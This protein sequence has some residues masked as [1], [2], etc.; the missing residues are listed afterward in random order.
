[1]KISFERLQYES[2]STGFRS[3]ILEKV[4]YLMDLLR[5]FS[6]DSYLKSRIALKGGTALNLFYF[7]YPRLS[8]D[9]DLNYIGSADL[10]SMREERMQLEK[11]MEK[12][13]L[14]EG[15]ISK[16]KP[17]EHAGGKW[18]LR[19][20]S[21][22]HGMGNL[23]VD[24]NYISRTPLWPINKLDSF[25]LGSYQITNIPI[26][27]KHEIAGSKLVALF[28]RHASRDLFDAHQILKNHQFDLKKLRLAFVIY[29]GL[30]RRDW[31]T[32]SID[33]LQ[34]DSHEFQNMLIPVLRRSHLSEMNESKKWA[35]SLLDESK[36]LLNV[37]F[38]FSQEELKFFD[39]LIEKGEIDPSLICTDE[40]LITK[41]VDHPGLKWKAINVK[42][43]N[44][45]VRDKSL[46]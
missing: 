6:E 5:L 3:E 46:T 43:F 34:L 26:L 17:S 35:K 20:P 37:L 38:P 18:I 45:I 9:I 13:I 28:A 32:V 40:A 7:D 11:V 25:K 31:R 36:S 21:A 16:R 12:I 39:K 22:V 10:D 1:M 44:A 8:V 29:G 24:I 4:I 33:D 41:I 2:E 23:E 15:L 19:Y 14:D 27:D 30:S 42:K